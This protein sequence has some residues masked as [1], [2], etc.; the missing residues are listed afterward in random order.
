[1]VFG[2]TAPAL[3]AVHNMECDWLGRNCRAFWDYGT[4]STTAWSNYKHLDKNH[5]SSVYGTT[6]SG[7]SVSK[8]SGCVVKGY[9]SYA[10][11]SNVTKNRKAYYRSC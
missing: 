8:D 1:M 9:W 6:P 4:T 11:I 7:S 10:S 3:A 5:G 2:S